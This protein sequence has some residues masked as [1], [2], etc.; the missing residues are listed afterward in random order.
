MRLSIHQLI[1]LERYALAIALI[2]TI[3]VGGLLAEKI[4]DIRQGTRDTA[5]NHAAVHLNRDQTLRFWAASHGGVYVPESE[6]TKP[7]P[8]LVGIPERDILTPSGQKLTLMNPAFMLRQLNENFA[9]I[10]QVQTHL[11]SLRPLR[12]ENRADDWE[13]Q[14]LSRLGQGE[15]E[16]QMFTVLR[17]QPY[18]RLMRPLF[19]DA[20]CLKCHAR[21]GYK[22]GDIL[23]G[24]SVSL[25]MTSFL[26]REK[27]QI[28]STLIPFALLWCFGLAGISIAA[29]R[30]QK[31]LAELASTEKKLL[32]SEEKFRTIADFTYDLEFWVDP[33]GHFIYVS[34]SAERITGYLAE[35]F[36]QNP[37]LLLSIIHPE[38]R[39][40]MADHLKN[41]LGTDAPRHLEFRITRKNGEERWI[42]HVC[43]PVY[44]AA[45][46]HL[47]RRTS[48]RDITSQKLAEEE[49]SKIAASLA[50][51]NRDLEDFAHIVSHDLQEPL[52]L[53][54]AFS[55][56]L[57]LKCKSSLPAQGCEYLHR[58]E[59]TANRMQD[60]I[61]GLLTYSR[62]TT[63]TTPYELIN[64]AEAIKEVMAD[65]EIRLEQSKGQVEVAE[66]ATVE[67][68]PL[69]I[70]QLLQNLIG[71]ALKY[72]HPDKKPCVKIYS[73]IIPQHQGKP[74][75]CRL[76][77]EDEGIG[78]EE[79]YQERIFKIFQR[80]H[81][82]SKYEG[83]GLGLTI[84]KKIVERHDGSISAKSSV[85][86]GTKFIVELPVRRSR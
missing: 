69:Q 79:Q 12:P 1:P 80:L 15:K 42:S 28:R 82:Q 21:E 56:R 64:L 63:H 61:D 52:N 26:E 2:W 34:P 71:N 76:T 29:R 81:D 4:I 31:K 30:L 59:M 33:A 47:G 10:L 25:P 8:Y 73:E 16:V 19:A 17:Q 37:E 11:A 32:E 62:V 75:I 83:V 51:S 58:I 53:I 49:K 27:R 9:G 48:N 84:C 72:H 78:F 41:E 55:N 67:A 86:Q 66:L 45:G 22:E 18:L 36:K 68:D 60:L 20:A 35:E 65:L 50:R 43:Q 77:I 39:P 3:L 46:K 38:D 6:S 23:G 40:L 24:I 14:A 44:N 7:N 5:I 57:E 13:S 74:A 54:K 70:R 85:G